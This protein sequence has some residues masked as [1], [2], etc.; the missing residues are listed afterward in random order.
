MKELF[1]KVKWTP[2]LLAMLLLSSTVYSDTLGAENA[3]VSRISC[4]M[5]VMQLLGY[6]EEA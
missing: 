4:L 5:D 3:P 1:R 2:V 6:E